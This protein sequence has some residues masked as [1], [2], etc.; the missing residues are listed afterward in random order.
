M[1]AGMDR[2]GWKRAIGF[3]NESS[4][5]DASFIAKTLHLYT[6]QDI[7]FDSK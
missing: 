7:I 2:F 3:R 5:K 6:D 4:F 1:A